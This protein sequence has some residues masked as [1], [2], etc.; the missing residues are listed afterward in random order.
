MRRSA[1][2]ALIALASLA[3]G[4]SSLF[5]QAAAPAVPAAAKCD[6]LC[7][8]PTRTIS[9]ETTEG[10][11]MN[12]DISP[13]GKTLL[14]D[15]LGDLYTVPRTGGTATR[16]TSGMAMDGQPVFSPDGKKIL[17]VS[18]RSGNM[19]L[20]TI[21]ADG[22]G[23]TA[24][25][26]DRSDAH[27]VNPE[28]APDGEYIL[29]QKN[30][31]PWLYHR[32]GGAGMQ[33]SKTATGGGHRWDPTG[34]FI[35]YMEAGGYGGPA[36]PIKRLDRKTADIATITI[37]PNGGSRPAI[38]PDGKWLVYVSDLDAKAGLRLHN[39]QTRD[40]QWLVYPIDWESPNYRTR[41]TFTPD[42][43]SVLFTTGG[44]FHEVDIS[45]RQVTKIAFKAHVEQQLGKLVYHEFPQPTDSFVVRNIRHGQMNRDHS[46]LVFASLNQL[47]IMDLPSG[48]PR[49]LVDGS[50]VYQPSFSPDGTSIAYVSWDQLDGGQ[51][52]R[53]PTSGGTP[54]KLT[55]NAAYYANLVWSPDGSKIAYVREDPAG[56]RTRDTR[57]SAMLEWIPSNGGAAQSVITIPSDNNITFAD[58]GTRLTFAEGGSLMSV[59]LDGVDKRTVVK[60]TGADEIVPSPDAKWVA[61]TIREEVYVAAVPPTGEAPSINETSGPAPTKRVARLGG[62]DLKWEDAGK[63]LTW[64]FDNRFFRLDVDKLFAATPA[65]SGDQAEITQVTL[66]A[67]M[68]HA[69]GTVAL[70]G[71]RV[72]TMRGDEVLNNA[73]IVVENGRVSAIGSSVKVPVGAKVIDVK[74]KTIIPG[75]VDMHA[76]IRG[77]PRDVFTQAAPEPLV[78]LAFG[79]TMSRDVNV[80]TDQY[81]YRELI[82][83]GRMLGPRLFVTGPSMTSGAVKVDSYEDAVAGTRRYANRGSIAI[84]QYMQPQRRQ[85]Q[86]FLMAADTLGINATAEGGGL[87]HEVA[88]IL[89][90][91]TC[92][93]H[94]PSDIVNI[95][96]DFVQL[97]AQSKT[98]YTPTLIVAS[99]AAYQGELYWYQTTNP[100]EDEK[101]Q[102]FLTHSAIDQ[103]TRKSTRYAEDEYYFVHGGAAAT[104]VL[105]A[106]GNVATGGHGQLH[107]IAVHWEMWMLQ[108]TGMTPMEVIRTSTIMG[109]NGLGMA[110]DYGSLEVGKVA[111]LLVLDKNPLENIR[112]STS[113]RYVMK[114]GELFEGNTL[115]MV[116]PRA[117][118]LRAFKYRDFGPPPKAE[119]FREEAKK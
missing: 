26:K 7:I 30:S 31:Q 75:L 43:S 16:L 110:K 35:Y 59:M 77:M 27:L 57:N 25:T 83:A 4:S 79:V 45:T 41:L 46:K 114:G 89:D 48:T 9:F 87:M 72:V 119:W 19:N 84:K 18:D 55:T 118:K 99:P 39:L 44:T 54:Q 29:V 15:L 102:R 61:Y 60:V 17:F 105:R 73:T 107:G 1:I 85:I 69:K 63:T 117:E 93:E 98:L 106:G 104:P 50:G 116:W 112:N 94:A 101:I 28:W 113:I 38:S 47:W 81:H 40:D 58:D 66:K 49:R 24:I 90:G 14:F 82:A 36:G 42:G 97:L 3:A 62:Q 34:R 115:D 12:V 71:A 111:D 53:V 109:A 108:M 6:S 65:P 22:S 51:I 100:H 8:K 78:N 64:V 10:T 5:A 86:W 91:Y 80:S 95:Y 76:H 11:Q 67:P 32:T 52:W 33:I 23:L 37:T 70:K 92:F 88:M 2:S 74:G 103:L 21:N 56:N 68:N 13:D 20:W 96:N